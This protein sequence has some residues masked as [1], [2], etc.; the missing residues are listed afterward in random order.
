M[1]G[2]VSKREEGIKRSRVQHGI[3]I[4][5]RSKIRLSQNQSKALSSS[6]CPSMSSMVVPEMRRWLID[7][8]P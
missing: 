4:Q 5:R 6:Q 7:F 8:H 3:L 1:E 2:V